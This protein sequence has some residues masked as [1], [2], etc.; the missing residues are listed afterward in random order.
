MEKRTAGQRIEDLER[1]ASGLYHSLDQ[2]SRENGMLKDAVHLLDNKVRAI[3]EAIK[4]S[5]Q[6]VDL[7]DDNLA[8]IMLGFRVDELKTKLNGLL[9]Q[10]ILKASE[11][12]AEESFV[13]G[14]EV[15][16]AGTV[17]NP[18]VQFALSAIDPNLRDKLKGSKA[19]D[20]VELAEGKWRL[21][22]LEVYAIVPPETEEAAAPEA[23]PAES[24][25]A[26]GSA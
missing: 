6:V 26:S 7:S 19:G 18:R 5:G 16:T 13:V 24:A 4:N 14:E 2:I 12:I 25:P 22:V 20:L 1:V 11:T 9:A 17:V 3:V 8:K 23:A 15:D 10:G 21:R